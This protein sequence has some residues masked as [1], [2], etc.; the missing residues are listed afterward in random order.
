MEMK[1]RNKP[2]PYLAGNVLEGE[3]PLR[4]SGTPPI[5]KQVNYIT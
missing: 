2:I 1:V 4:S 5:P 3:R